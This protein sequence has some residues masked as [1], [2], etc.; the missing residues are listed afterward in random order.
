MEK[1]TNQPLGG[2]NSKVFAEVCQQA[3]TAGPKGTDHLLHVVKIA[4]ALT[5]LGHPCLPGVEQKGPGRAAHLRG[6]QT[7]Q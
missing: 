3:N 1:K 6:G 7:G 4:S 2:P 5:A